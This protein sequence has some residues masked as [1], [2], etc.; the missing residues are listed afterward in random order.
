MDGF[1]VHA[2]SQRWH[3]RYVISAWTVSRRV[4]TL[5][6][7]GYVFVRESA[8]A[9]TRSAAFAIIVALTMFSLMLCHVIAA[10][11]G[12]E[13]RLCIVP[14]GHGVPTLRPMLALLPF[15]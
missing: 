8:A 3:K 6:P 9:M 4:G 15:V 1:P 7:R 13:P 12:S 11:I 2:S 14:R 10:R 5:C